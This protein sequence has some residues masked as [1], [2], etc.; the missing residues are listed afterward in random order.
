MSSTLDKYCG[1]TFWNDSYLDRPDPDF[2][3]CLEQTV[4]VWIPLG[5]LWI[6]APWQLPPLFRPRH[7]RGRYSKLYLVKQA[8]SCLLFL[9][10]VIGLII[11][12]L[13]DL[14]NYRDPTPDKLN[15]LVLYVNPSIYAA[16]WL[17]MLL[18]HESR[19][20][21]NNENSPYLFIFWL[22]S[23]LCG[24]FM[25]QTLIRL[26]IKEGSTPDLPRFSLFCISYGLE[27]ISF[28]ASCISDVSSEVKAAAEKNPQVSASFLSQITFH[29]YNR[30]MIKGYKKPLETKHLWELNES[31]K[32][33]TI[34]ANFERYMI[35]DLKE[36]W[37]KME[38]KQKR[39]IHKD[40]EQMN[41]F[42]RSVSQD[43]LVM[44][45]KSRK[46]KKKKPKKEESAPKVAEGWLVLSIMKT[47]RL[48]LIKGV[49]FKLF[50]DALS[51][52]SPQ[53]LKLMIS[54]TADTSIYLWKGYLYAILL[55]VTALIQSLILQQ[56]F[57]CCFLLGMRVRTAI[58]AAVYKK[59]LT[60]S[61]A[62]RKE[63]TVGEIVNLMAVDAQRL[64][65]VTNF[66]HLLWSAPLQI[67][68]GIAF[69]WEE[70]GPSTLAGLAVMI[71]LIPV[72]GVLASR[73]RNL[74][75]KNMKHKDQRMKL[76]NEILNGIKVM[77]FYAWEPSFEE[78]VLGIREKELKVMKKSSY[79]VA[80][81]LFLITC[82]PFIV[83]LT[84]FA[85]YLAVDP[86]N[87]LDAEKA[88]TSISLFNIM[89]FPL[90]MLPML[91]S[92]MV[93][94]RVSCKRL[95]RFL[96]GENL[97][98]SA[99]QQDPSFESAVS[100]SDATFSWNKNESPAIKNV[101]L[102]I[103]PGRLVAVVG[104]VGSGKSSLISALLG[105]MENINGFINVKGSFAY[106]PQQAWIQNDILQN[107]ILFGLE[108]E[109]SRY[110][111]VLEACA[112][113]PDLEL[114]PA[115]DQTE[116]GEKGINLSGGQKQRVSLARAAYST[117]EIIILDDPLSA[118]DAHVG[119]HIFEKVIGPNG[120]F[121]DKTRI[122]VTHGVTF[123]PQMDEIVVLVDGKV[124]EVGSYKTLKANKGA[125]AD[126]L[127]TYGEG[128]RSEEGEA[129][130]NVVTEED[131]TL[132]DDQEPQ[133]DEHPSDVVTLTL[134][135]ENS[136]R[137]RCRKWSK[138][139]VRVSLKKAMRDKVLASEK[140]GHVEAVKGQRLIEKEAVETGKVKYSVYWKYLRMIGW[141]YSLLIMVLYI[142]QNVATIGQN[143]W[144]S[145]WTSDASY[146]ANTT[147]PSS[148][149]DKRIGIF[150]VLGIAQAV[151]VFL[152]LFLIT[153][154][155]IAASR[156]LHSRLLHNI[157]HVPMLFFDTTPTG[158]IVNRFSKDIYTIDETIP[159]TFRS[160]LSCFFGVIGTLFVICLATPYFT[161][162]I[163]PLAIIYYFIQI[164]YI[165]TSRQL[166]RLESV[167]GSP[168][169]SHFS[170]TVTGLPII[171]AY[172][173]QARF[174][175][176]NEQIINGNVKCIFP[177]IVANRWLAVRLEFVGNLVVFFA[178]LFS[179]TSRGS[180]ASGLVGLSISYALNVTQALNWLVRQ[181]SELETNIVSVERVSEYTKLD[182]EAPWVMDHRPE[183][184][185]P[186]KGEIKFLDY[187][188]RYRP[189]LDLVL[190]GLTCDIRPNEKI[191]IVG[192][193]GAGKSSLTNCLFRIIE[194]AG[195]KILIDGL[196]I[197]TIGLHDLRQRLTIIPQD[198]V[199]FSS[200]FRMN[201]DPFNRYTDEEVWRSLELAHLKQYTHSLP[202][203]L[204]HQVSEGGE[205][206]SVGQ[207][208]LLCLARALLRKSKILILDE[209]TAA[210][211]LETDDLIQTTVRTE[212]AD[213]TVLTIAHRLHTIMDSTRVMVLD[214]GRIVEFDTPSTL[215]QSQG[216]FYCMVKDAGIILTGDTAF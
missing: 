38:R 145:D 155:T 26:A 189:E 89:R 178:A 150:G 146:Y 159:L 32:T 216:L 149:R 114:L 166:R 98:T 123:L 105:E 151:F 118:V 50:H 88:F 214:A 211:D 37:R 99:I 29:W 97:D 110:Q 79:V 72:N 117:A 176:N 116:I 199:L 125:F 120:L 71:I 60:V 186:D 200:T 57:Q 86:N 141:M 4:L 51:F 153:E 63:S 61:N 175:M 134:K 160:W 74:Q 173:H 28:I 126:F 56:Y 76:M 183:K 187:E 208:Q 16:T 158:R 55:F 171:R 144:L 80:A 132:G 128:D 22:L 136:E 84:S 52:V 137:A 181:T 33:Q 167:T 152:G 85:V 69:L 17:M 207:R 90:M 21:T 19:R 215:L 43:I 135:R 109:E 179:V 95:E 42:S 169:Y 182:N 210:I 121:K 106:V 100:F 194:S 92:S 202:N 133:A 115:G 177:R 156:D 8:L 53:L 157:L 191:G 147:Y 34:H 101:T 87:V 127:N 75:V 64:N 164:F 68:V 140:E 49:I 11:T 48:V 129:T 184:D 20:R 45:E 104:P 161:I 209:A 96:G 13:E 70:L 139:S 30:M 44:E 124:S 111:K 196:D 131:L 35:K 67:L 81:S 130:V 122:L 213:C 91:I 6:C 41:G 18:I 112:L 162:V 1:S 83:I 113:L 185:W 15:P 12:L 172:G 23:V 14:G 195:G 59:A 3:V 148:E 66:I 204:Q 203:K 143:L 82:T 27:C 36:A 108:R 103:K 62:A 212:F 168:I 40:K 165:V 5:F 9:T 2:P 198:P 174:L 107:N 119:K 46:D 47:F 206:L 78:Q 197:S 77:K 142:A 163:V 58:I 73:T 31:D 205:N 65:D 54:F 10:S 180:L 7:S 170:E 190:H 154:G 201:L 102:D 25:L 138:S 93:Q 188:V 39:E 193:T 192:R 24:V 94:A